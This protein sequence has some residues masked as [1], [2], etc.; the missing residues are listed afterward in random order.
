MARYGVFWGHGEWSP[1]E[2]PGKTNVPSGCKLLLFARHK[3][4]INTDRMVVFPARVEKG[5]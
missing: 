5:Q 4:A 3:E 1:Q 2:N